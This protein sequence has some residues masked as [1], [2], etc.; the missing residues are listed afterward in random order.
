MSDLGGYYYK[1][2]SKFD[3]SFLHRVISRYE[4]KR[5]VFK[6]FCFKHRCFGG[7][8]SNPM[9]NGKICWYC[10]QELKDRVK[11]KANER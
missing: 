6:R 7:T 2:P 11:E 8:P 5:G 10:Y 1:L 3:N 9:Y 4:L